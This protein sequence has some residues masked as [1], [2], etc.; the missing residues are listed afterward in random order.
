MAAVAAGTRHCLSC[1]LTSLF[2][3]LIIHVLFVSLFIYSGGP[4]MVAQWPRYCAT[5]R[6]VA[7]SIPDG[8]IGIFH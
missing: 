4:L 6:K 7:A 2:I 5:N 3:N 1:L 8:A